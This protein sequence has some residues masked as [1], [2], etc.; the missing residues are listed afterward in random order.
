MDINESKMPSGGDAKFPI[1]AETE[2]AGEGGWK[3]PP[4]LPKPRTSVM[5]GAT[6][7]P[8][9]VTLPAVS[10]DPPPDLPSFVFFVKPTTIFKGSRSPNAELAMD[11][12]NGASV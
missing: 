6:S 12:L 10:L 11:T 4:P 3:P 8:T 2:E 1:D 7:G 5:G 9:L